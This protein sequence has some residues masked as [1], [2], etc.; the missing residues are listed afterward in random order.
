MVYCTIK[1]KYSFLCGISAA[2]SNVYFIF[3]H[4]SFYWIIST[5]FRNTLNMAIS[6]IRLSEL[7]VYEPLKKSINILIISILTAS[8]SV[9]GMYSYFI[10]SQSFEEDHLCVFW[11]KANKYD[12]VM[13]SLKKTYTNAEKP[14]SL[15]KI[16][17]SYKIF[18]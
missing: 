9:Q 18:W 10:L 17:I 8:E 5:D 7:R 1:L 16:S 2:L 11:S 13:I 12:T 3:T 4:L 6:K 14:L 15:C